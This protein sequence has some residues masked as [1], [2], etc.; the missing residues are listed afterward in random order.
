MASI[1]SPPTGEVYRH[2]MTVT[3]RD[4]HHNRRAPTGQA[5]QEAEVFYRYDGSKSAWARKDGHGSRPKRVDTS[6]D[7]AG[8]SALGRSA[9]ATPWSVESATCAKF[10]ESCNSPLL[11]ER[12]GCGIGG[13]SGD[14]RTQLPRT[15]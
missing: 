5:L 6:V 7:A 4:H 12:S 8:R 13:A 15:W 2:E 11:E 3:I 14:A 9:C 1:Q 10:L